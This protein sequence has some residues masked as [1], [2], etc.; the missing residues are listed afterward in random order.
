[1][2]SEVRRVLRPGGLFLFDTINRT[3]L[4]TFVI[5][6]IGEGMIG[7]LPRGT[8]DPD[9]VHPPLR[10]QA[11]RWSGT[12]SS[13]GGSPASGRGA[14][15]AGSVTFGRW[16]TTAVQYLGHAHVNEGNPHPRERAGR[17]CSSHR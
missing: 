15:T 6:T 16:P 14:W 7:L 4:A 8:H 11:D 5:V 1:M 2:V 13:S 9:D 3:P 10:A 17:D 12:A